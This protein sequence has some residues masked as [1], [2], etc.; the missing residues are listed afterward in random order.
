MGFNTELNRAGDY[1]LIPR[2]MGMRTPW[3]QPVLAGYCVTLGTER[4]SISEHVSTIGGWAQRAR[5]CPAGSWDRPGER[6]GPRIGRL[7]S[8]IKL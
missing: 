3:A 5:V 2:E 1:D 7:G 6:C 4:L 8:R